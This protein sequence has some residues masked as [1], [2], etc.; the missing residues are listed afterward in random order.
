MTRFSTFK[1]MRVVRRWLVW[2]KVPQP[3]KKPLK[4]PFYV[5]GATR[6]STDTPEDW[7]QLASYDDAKAALAQRGKDWGL[8]FAL[9]P[10]GTGGHWQGIDLDQ[11]EVKGLGRLANRWVREDLHD[12]GHVEISPSGTGQ[13]VIGYGRLFAALGSNTTGIEAYSS[14]RFFTVT[15]REVRADSP[16]HVVDLAEYVE[17][18][19][20]PLHSVGRDAPTTGKTVEVGRVSAKTVSEL[21]SALLHMRAD[22]YDLWIRM[23]LGLRELGDVGRELWLSWSATSDKFNPKE[24]SRKW[25]GFAP[26]NTGYQA[27]FAE[28]QR[29]G[30]VN[31]G[32]KAAQLAPASGA[33]GFGR[34]RD[35]LRQVIPPPYEFD[36]VPPCI[37]DFARAYSS[38]TGH[39]QSG[40]IISAVTAAA[41]VIDDGFKLMVRPQSNWSVSARQW[42]F[43]CGGPSA[44]KSPAIR[45]AT[46]RIKSMHNEQFDRWTSACEGLEKGEPRPPLPA[47][48]TSDSTVAALADALVANERGLL[49]LTEEMSSWIGAIDSS[50]KGD[51]SKNRGDWLQLRD[52]GPRQINRVER[53]AMLVKNWGVSVLAA[54]TPNGLADNMKSMPE[55]GLIQRFVPCILAAPNLEAVIGDAREATKL[56]GDWLEYAW[57]ATTSTFPRFL[58]LTDEARRLFDAEELQIRRM[59]LA[60]QEFAPA[61]AAHLGKHPGMLAEVALVFHVLLGHQATE[62]G[63]DAMHYAIRYMRKVRRHAYVLYSTILSSAP[64]FELAQSLARSIVA[65]DEKVPTVGRDWMTQHCQAF[66]KADDRVRRGA[67]QILED[68]DWLNAHAQARTYGGWPSK[69]NVN[70]QVFD[71]FAPEGEQWRARRAAVKDAIGEAEQ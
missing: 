61:Y 34:P 25:D 43:L 17:R 28:A 65:C 30:W 45:A 36:E 68:A 69:Y 41:S 27:V 44:G 31:P 1:A 20:A 62:V 50:N 39:D 70:P 3:D 52:G 16:G 29:N 51:A 56:W 5:N 15:E 4:V 48:Y 14:G 59:L 60:T 47:M 40:V 10:D 53:G 57:G 24:A 42:A 2:K 12:W 22:E 8:A 18:E 55:D 38:A 11:I 66:K 64:A 35:L 58:T 49:M 26:T 19:L 37:A 6:G 13:H 33:S 63:S 32:S 46:E 9:G 7:A 71:L 67:V 54:C 23:G 21:R